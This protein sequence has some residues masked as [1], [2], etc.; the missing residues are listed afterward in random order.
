[1]EAVK[2]L[3]DIIKEA[4]QSE[5]GILAL[6]IV[7]VGLLAYV[8]F[9]TSSDKVKLIAFLLIFAGAAAYGIAVVRAAHPQGSGAAAQNS[10]AEHRDTVVIA[11]TVVDAIDGHG[12][13]QAQVGLAGAAAATTADGAGNFRFRAPPQSGSVRLVVSGRGY[14]E[15]DR[16]ITP[17]V[18]NLIL[19]LERQ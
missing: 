13:G 19:Q 17:P 15:L 14:R 5:L 9:R 4:S 7:A 10:A 12:I 6:L 11:G 8:F 18:E 3:P 1:M 16:L 2:T